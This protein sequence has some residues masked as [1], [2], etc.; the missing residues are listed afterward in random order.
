MSRILFGEVNRTLQ[1]LPLGGEWLPLGP[2]TSLTSQ[3][4][5]FEVKLLAPV[6]LYEH[7][8]PCLLFGKEEG[9][10]GLLSAAETQLSTLHARA[11]N[12]G[13]PGEMS[14]PSKKLSGEQGYVSLSFS[15]SLCHKYF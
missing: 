15:V 1:T 11:R 10:P 13:S 12:S 7:P 3:A 2:R 9:G 4:H 5:E 6:T 14:F 8:P